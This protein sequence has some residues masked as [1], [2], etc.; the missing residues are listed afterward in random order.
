[1]RDCVQ[2]YVVAAIQRNNAKWEEVLYPKM[3]PHLESKR[4][5]TILL[6]RAKAEQIFALMAS[7]YSPDNFFEKYRA[8]NA[9]AEF[10]MIY[11]EFYMPARKVQPT[12]GDR[13]EW[14]G[15]LERRL[16]DMELQAFDEHEWNAVEI[17]AALDEMMLS[18]YKVTLSYQSKDKAFTATVMD[19][20]K[21]SMTAGYALSATD[22]TGFGALCMLLYKHIEILSGEWGIL[23][24]EGRPTR[25]G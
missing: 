14:Q 23:L 6:L 1:L 25:R 5:T 10:R 9:F 7:Y 3:F 12:T 22:G 13:P 15:F 8:A 4:Y 16:S 20:R 11:T 21:G 18:G 24:G 2:G 19:Q 17:L